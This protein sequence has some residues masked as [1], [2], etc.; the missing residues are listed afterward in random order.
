MPSGRCPPSSS[1]ASG[2]GG[3]GGPPLRT[4]GKE[5]DERIRFEL[6]GIGKSKPLYRPEDR[7]P[8]LDPALLESHAEGLILLT[9][10]RQG[11]LSQLI[12]ADQRREAEALLRDYVKWFGAE[13][14]VVELQHNRVYGDAQRV[15]RLVQ[16]AEQ[17]GMRYAA[18]GNVH[19][20][21]P[22][23]HRL[24]DVLVAIKHQRTLDNSHRERRP[25]AQ[26][27]LR[28][29]REMRELF[30]RYPE[31]LATTGWIAD[32]CAAF[33]LT[34]NLN[35]AFPDYPTAHGETPDEALAH[36][37]RTTLVERYTEAERAAAAARLREELAVIAHHGLAGFFLLYRDLL[38]LARE[39]AD[40][41]RGTNSA[42]SAANLPPGRGRGS[43]VSSIVC[44]LI[45]LSHIDPVKNNLF[46]GRF[47]NEELYAVPD[48]DL[49][50]PR[51][52]RE[53]LIER[54]HE[55]YGDG[56]ALVCAFSTYRL[57]SAVRD[58]GK[59]LGLP[60]PDID[61]IAK[62]SEP[63]SAHD[64]SRELDRI[65][66]YAE[67][68]DNPPWSYLVEL[69][70]QLAGFPRHVTQHVGGMVV[71]AG[72]LREIV[73]VQPAAMEGRFLCQWDKDSCDDARMVKIDFLALG[74]LSLVEECLELMVAAGKE[75]TDL[76]R[77][78]FEDPKV[79]EMI[80]DGDTVGV[81]QI[82]SRAQIQM[83]PRT[84]PRNLDDLAVQVAIVRPGPII[85]G[86]VTPYV[87]HRQKKRTSFLP[88][89]PHYDHPCLEPV[90]EETHG[91]VLFQEQVLQVAMAYAGFTPGEAEGFRRA[92]SR[93][94]SREAM[95][96]LR[97]KFITGAI[98]RHRGT[99]HPVTR[100]E[101]ENVFTKLAG[102]AS[103]GFPKAHAVAFALLAYQSCWLKYY[104]PAEFTCALLNN[105]PMG[106]YPPHVLINDAKRHRLRILSPDVNL[107]GVR[108]SLDGTNGIRIGLGYV[109]ELGEEPAR[110]IVLERE[111]NGDYRSLADFVR[112]VPLPTAA[113]ENLIAVGGFDRFGLGRRE[114]LWQIGLFVSSQ[115]F[116]TK[117]TTANGR[118]IPLALPVGQDGVELRPMGAWDQ[119]AADYA[120]LGLSPRYHPLGLLRHRLPAHFV[121]TADLDRLPHG[122]EIEIAGLTV[123]R[124]RPG[125]A[126]GITFL[127]LEDEHGLVN[128]IVYPG[129]YE[130]QRMV[131]RGEPFV[132]VT[133]TLQKQHDTINVICRWIRPMENARQEFA[134]MPARDLDDVQPRF[135]P[136]RE[137]E[138]A[139]VSPESHN[140]R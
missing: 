130:R 129:L 69:A 6:R 105:Q 43:S 86:A 94:R 76:S 99:E 8:R 125:T 29:A 38:V 34:R 100:A 13:N 128:V 22:E 41:V 118:Q 11:R 134:G 52:I 1:A 3:H 91:V 115:R 45:G 114:A 26:F 98:A 131:V 44:Y 15:Q 81:F 104:H 122:T 63:R 123:C 121:M 87:E 138:L 54:V 117:R 103:Y 127:L 133:G 67:R 73:P 113:V 93:K 139:T 57:R 82:E 77:I 75:P 135:A 80:C 65:P 88:I 61:K 10:C 110:R 62:L 85:G 48:I 2:E 56:A 37:C 42:R 111:A 51:E 12:D 18:T 50:F 96:A 116:G 35:Y 36:V 20:H 124:Q 30:Q 47:L 17:V 59:A 83:L 112:R 25:N 136:E 102:F 24:Q 137:R 92:M 4:S 9:G 58:V 5:G 71:A 66:G 27:Y 49:D 21:R 46:F 16:V 140:Y 120:V 101:A 19:Y 119:M 60:Q 95:E 39:V 33:D 109:K 68:K 74:M 14:V 126:K 84:R 79:Y 90:L 132:V 55:K 64:L 107:S 23:R 72:S 32:R 40:E 31:A 108:C 7:T 106:F 53:R 97:E 78:D 28:S 70:D 89:E